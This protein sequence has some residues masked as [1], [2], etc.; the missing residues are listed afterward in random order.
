MK[1]TLERKEY[2]TY[3]A[4]S[5]FVDNVWLCY[6]LEDKVRDVK[7]YGKTAIAYGI[8]DVVITMSNRFKK[9]LPLLLNVPNFE[10]IRI[11]SGNTDKDTDGCIL[12]GM[13]NGDDG[14]LGNSRTAMRK[15]MSELELAIKSGEKVTIEVKRADPI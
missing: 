12:V 3:S 11:H 14:F 4:G 2:P 7:I 9:R 5:L 8:Y 6:T 1:L 10:G 13:E 15:L